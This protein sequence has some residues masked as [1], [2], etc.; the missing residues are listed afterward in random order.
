[1]NGIR[2]KPSGGLWSGSSRKNAD[3]QFEEL[4]LGTTYAQLRHLVVKTVTTSVAR[5]AGRMSLALSSAGRVH[6][7]GG[8]IKGAR[9]LPT[10]RLLGRMKV[11]LVVEA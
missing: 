11:P 8:E 4:E 2:V 7:T 6:G 1:M 3:L 10:L 5:T 9:G